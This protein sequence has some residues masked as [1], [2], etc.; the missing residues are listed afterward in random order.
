MKKANQHAIKTGKLVK[1]I[2]AKNPSMSQ[3]QAFALA[4]K[5]ASSKGN[6]LYLNPYI[7]RGIKV[8]QDAQ[9]VLWYALAACSVDYAHSL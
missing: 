8:K 4:S 1:E 5:Q 2:K 6:G 9:L 3:K 7:G